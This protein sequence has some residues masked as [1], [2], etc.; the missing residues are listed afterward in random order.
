[1]M[2]YWTAR[3]IDSGSLHI[4]DG[5]GLSPQNRVSAKALATALLY[6]G[7]QQWFSSF[8]KAL[9]LINGQHMKSG[10]IEGARAYAG[11]QRAANGRD[12]IF[13][14]IVNNYQGA[15]SSITKKLWTLLDTL[16]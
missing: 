6:A 5:S 3:G 9:P 12:Y 13:A 10:S 2:E 1:M 16:K 14:I 4:L 15:P 7:K 8:Y 11:Y